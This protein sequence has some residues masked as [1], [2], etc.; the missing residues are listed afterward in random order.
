MS[1]S[2]Y[3]F[4]PGEAALLAN[5]CLAMTEEASP[6]LSV[7]VDT[8]VL[9]ER[10]RQ[11]VARPIGKL[12]VNKAIEEQVVVKTSIPKSSH[13]RRR[14][15]VLSDVAVLYL[16][17]SK[18]VEVE[19]KKSKKIEV[20]RWLNELRNQLAHGI[21]ISERRLQLDRVTVLEV[22]SEFERWINFIE[23][24]AKTREK[25]IHSDPEIM[26]GLPVISNTRIPVYSV[27]A[28]IEGGETIEDLLEDY[29][30]I[31]M[32]AFEAAIAFARTHPREGRP[33]KFR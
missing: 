24:Y 19:L 8:A 3:D 12:T 30:N 4:N 26:G 31:P 18:L 20:Y 27:L 25:Y 22:G 21:N 16:A 1:N 32:K 10:V 11:I 29:P 5:I 9:E 2:A 33:R 7:S 17:F 14:Y 13:G 15:R 6:K 23:D 28:R